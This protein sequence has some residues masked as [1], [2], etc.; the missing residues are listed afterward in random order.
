V[1]LDGLPL[2]G[3]DPRNKQQPPVFSGRTF[4]VD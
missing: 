2:E 3:K 1:G 4:G